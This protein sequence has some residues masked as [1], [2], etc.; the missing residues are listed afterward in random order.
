MNE[1]MKQLVLSLI[2]FLTACAGGP[3]EDI[4]I[5]NGKLA[6]C[7]RSPNCVS[8][9]AIDETHQIE[10]IAANLDQIEGELLKLNEANIVSMDRTYLHAEF[11]SRFMHYVD[12]VEFLFDQ[13]AGLVHVRSASRVGYSDLGVN[14]KRIESIRR[15]VKS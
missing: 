9:Y 7:P 12:D 11:T 2:P 15:A 5:E 4:G 10:P 14:R 13:A 1:E 8:S 3:P 6:P